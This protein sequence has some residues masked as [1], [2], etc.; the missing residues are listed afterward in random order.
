M[1]FGRLDSRDG[2]GSGFSDLGLKG[3]NWGG[4]RVLSF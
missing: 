3:F 1:L 4:L 2:L